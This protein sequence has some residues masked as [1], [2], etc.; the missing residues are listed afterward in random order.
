MICF[1]SRPAIAFRQ[2]AAVAR[3]H[4][5]AVRARHHRVHAS[6]AIAPGDAFDARDEIQVLAHR[7]VGIERRRFRQVAG[8]PLRFDGPIENVVARD[9]RASVRGG[10]VAREDAHRGRFSRA[11][12]AQ[13]PQDFSFFHAEADV[14]DGGDLAVAFGEVLDLYQ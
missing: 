14:V 5:G 8:A 2:L 3:G 9:D 10:D 6:L 7:H 4:V 13:K 11:V 1:G 12:G